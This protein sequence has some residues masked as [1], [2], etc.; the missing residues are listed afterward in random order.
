MAEKVQFRY[1]HY[2]VS[3]SGLDDKRRADQPRGWVGCFNEELAIDY[4]SKIGTDRFTHT[5]YKTDPGG[6]K[7]SKYIRDEIEKTDI[8]LA[9]VSIG[10]NKSVHC[11]DERALFRDMC[12]RKAIEAADRMFTIRLDRSE[13]PEDLDDQREHIFWREAPEGGIQKVGHPVPKINPEG[14]YPAISRLADGMAEM[15]LTLF[16]HL[17]S[18][19]TLVRQSGLRLGAWR[20]MDR[21][22]VEGEAP[23]DSDFVRE[24]AAKLRAKG[25]KDVAYSSAHDNRAAMSG[26][27]LLYF[28][29]RVDESKF[30]VVL[31]QNGSEEFAAKR[32]VDAKNMFAPPKKNRQNVIYIDAGRDGLSPDQCAKRVIA[33]LS[34][35]QR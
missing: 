16:P 11:S 20:Y 27:P 22:Y 4:G 14:F 21:I 3:F 24:T 18:N 7:I 10:A 13:R 33:E 6:G 15:S 23:D 31:R 25:C 2:F 17:S 8:F 35:P 12:K 9:L 28:R 32:C 30:V 34:G 1:P 19:A 26:D 29:Q 5:Y